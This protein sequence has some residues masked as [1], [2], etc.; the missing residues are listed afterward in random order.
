MTGGP[1]T[2]EALSCGVP[3]PP[4]PPTAVTRPCAHMNSQHLLVPQAGMEVYGVISCMW[5]FHSVQGQAKG[6]LHLL[7][8]TRSSARWYCY[9]PS[10]DEEAGTPDSPQHPRM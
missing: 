3:F 2:G 10:V 6:W 8:R 4:G 9:T 7:A 5:R 1:E